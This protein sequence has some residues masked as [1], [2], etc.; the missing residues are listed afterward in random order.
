M[1]PTFSAQFCTA[2]APRRGGELGSGPL[3]HVA[4]NR[5]N[6]ISSNRTQSSSS[7]SKQARDWVIDSIIVSDKFSRRR[8]NRWRRTMTRPWRRTCPPTRLQQDWRRGLEGPQA[9]APSK[10]WAERAAT[11]LFP[12]GVGR[13]PVE[14]QTMTLVIVVTKQKQL[15]LD[16]DKISY[17][18]FSHG[19]LFVIRPTAI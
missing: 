2:S 11:T 19:F 3:R 5:S 4:I 12:G 18:T 9:T 7:V 10:R 15:S 1:H 14:H 6:Q 17:I 16:N 13:L 8:F